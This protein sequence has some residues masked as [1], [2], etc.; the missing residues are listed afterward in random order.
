MIYGAASSYTGDVVEILGRLSWKILGFI[1]NVGGAS[2]PSHL[3]PV[4]G[5]EDVPNSWLES[6]VVIPLA[7]PR[8]RLV[9]EEQARSMGFTRFPPVVDPMSVVAN[10][11]VLSEGCIVNAGVVIAAGAE[12]HGF[13]SVNRN[14]SVG[15]DATLE[16]YTFVG[17]GATLCGSTRIGRGTF[18]GA[19][20]VILPGVTIGPDAVVGAGAVVTKDVPGD[21]VVAGNPAQVVRSKGTDNRGFAV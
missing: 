14:A 1:D 17:P 9:A 3:A 19:G 15:H 5:P 13:A 18:I 2:L 8:H 11:A 7:T 20:A 4:V 12:F 10:S 16:G 21:T 6:A